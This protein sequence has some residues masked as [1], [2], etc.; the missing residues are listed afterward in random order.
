LGHERL[1]DPFG[2]IWPSILIKIAAGFELHVDVG[3]G[4]APIF[5]ARGDS[6]KLTV[7]IGT[8]DQMMTI[9]NASCPGRNIARTHDRFAFVLD[10]Y[11]FARENDDQFVLVF[12]PVPLRRP[13]ARP[14]H[15]MA[16]PHQRQPARRSQPAPPPA[17]DLLVE[18]RWIAGGVALLNHF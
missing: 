4:S 15:D 14:Q 12:M 1:P 10:E 11:C 13:R 7:G 18:R 5:V 9:G 16:C 6:D 3:I 8:V 17:F 2:G